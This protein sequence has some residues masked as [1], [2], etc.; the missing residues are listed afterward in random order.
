MP[1]TPSR[2]VFPNGILHFAQF[3]RALQLQRGIAALDGEGQRVAGAD[4]DDALHVGEAADLLAVDRGDDVADLE[5]RPLR[6][7]CWPRS[8][9]RAPSCSACRRR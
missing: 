2:C 5:A 1:R 7:R 3:R 4:A 8:C 9:R 6:R